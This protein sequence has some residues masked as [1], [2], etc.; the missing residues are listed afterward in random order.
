LEDSCLLANLFEGGLGEN[1]SRDY[2][3]ENC[4]YSVKLAPLAELVH[5]PRVNEF[6][7][8]GCSIKAQAP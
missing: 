6:Y 3:K 1:W 2:S 8:K 5:P 4:E 7:K